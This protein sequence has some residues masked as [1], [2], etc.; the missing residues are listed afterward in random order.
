M[1]IACAFDHAGFPLKAMVLAFSETE[2]R[3]PLLI[4]SAEK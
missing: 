3:P 2:P 1:K 4:V